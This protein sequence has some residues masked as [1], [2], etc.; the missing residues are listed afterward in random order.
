MNQKCERRGC[1]NDATHKGT[2]CDRCRKE[3]DNRNRQFHVIGRERQIAALGAE[4]ERNILAQII[5]AF[6]E[7]HLP[8]P[9]SV[10][11]RCRRAGVEIGG[12]NV[13][14]L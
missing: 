7:A 9:P 5:A 1:S 4:A 3:L 8:L 14:V 12:R 11:E 13:E 2:L 10:I 6:D